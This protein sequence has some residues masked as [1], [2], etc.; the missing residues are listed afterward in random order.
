SSPAPTTAAIASH[1]R[2]PATAHA[3]AHALT[4]AFLTP[5]DVT[6]SVPATS[7]VTS[8]ATA[9][10]AAIA[11]GASNSTI[12]ATAGRSLTLAVSPL[13]ASA[14][15]TPSPARAHQFQWVLQLFGRDVHGGQIVG[16]ATI[17]SLTTSIGNLAR[18]LG[19]SWSVSPPTHSPPLLA[20]S[21]RGRAN[22][23]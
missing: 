7:A 12:S 4:P 10:D 14:P 2:A 5:A 3:T 17:G 20:P 16:D 11:R 18:A 21:G 8:A 19:T 23:H 13:L 22:G 15:S 9:L 1:L 6:T